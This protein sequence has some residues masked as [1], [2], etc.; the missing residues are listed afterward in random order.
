MYGNFDN[1]D[2]IISCPMSANPEV[3]SY[4][5]Y[6]ETGSL[7]ADIKASTFSVT[8]SNGYQTFSCEATNA[9]GTST[10]V[11][12]EVIEEQ[13]QREWNC[14]QYVLTRHD[15]SKLRFLETVSVNIDTS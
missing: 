9:I 14:S 10:L 7:L 5:F 8:S 12:I 6:N 3:L 1:G 4:V 13:D 15:C 2:I 11:Y